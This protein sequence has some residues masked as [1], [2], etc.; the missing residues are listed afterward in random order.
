MAFTDAQVSSL[1]EICGLR[2]LDMRDYL[3]FYADTI[4]TADIE[5]EIAADI[6]LWNDNR[7]DFV[8]IIHNEANRGADIDPDDLRSAII[9]RV[10]LKLNFSPQSSN[11]IGRLQR[12]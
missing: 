1:A 3:N 5:D 9:R 12:V 10:R 7:D 4:R 8:R 6:I 11:G 2:Y